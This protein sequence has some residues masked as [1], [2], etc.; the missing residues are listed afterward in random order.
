M[1]TKMV[2]ISL[3]LFSL[4]FTNVLTAEINLD[5]VRRLGNSV[6]GGIPHLTQRPAIFN[7]D[8]WQTDF[9][10]ELMASKIPHTK[11]KLKLRPKDNQGP[12]VM[13][14]QIRFNNIMVGYD[15][16]FYTKIRVGDQIYIFDNINPNGILESEHRAKRTFWYSPSG[17]V[18]K[19]V[20]VPE[21]PG[22]I[23][24]NCVD[25]NSKFLSLLE[26]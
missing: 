16:H 25:W 20:Q 23:K 1:N 17:E 24:Y 14:A 26:S 11:C 18:Y 2:I 5:E 10:N 19:L 8:T 3:G 7:C 21:N 15:T 6:E 4:L 22:N 9:V 12:T 13:E